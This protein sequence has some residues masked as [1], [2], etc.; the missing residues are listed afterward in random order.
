MHRSLP[1]PGTAS[2]R[3]Q[4][5]PNTLP[6]NGLGGRAES[7]AVR[8]E[9]FPRESLSTA[10]LHLLQCDV[11][12]QL[13][14]FFYPSSTVALDETSLFVCM[15]K[16]WLYGEPL[17]RAEI[18]KTHFDLVSNTLT[19]WIDE[20]EATATLRRPM[21]AGPG[22]RSELVGR[23]LA[24]NKVR[25]T[26]WK[27]KSL[28]DGLSTE[29]LLCMAFRAMTNTEGLETLFRDGLARLELGMSELLCSI[30]PKIVITTST[31]SNSIQ[32]EDDI[33]SDVATSRI[34]SGSQTTIHHPASPHQGVVGSTG[35]S[36]IKDGGPLEELEE[37]PTEDV[38][39]S[40]KSG[41][42]ILK[43]KPSSLALLGQHKH[44]TSEAPLERKRTLRS[45]SRRE[46]TESTG[47]DRF[48]LHNVLAHML[49]ESAMPL[50]DIQNV[51]QDCHNDAR[52]LAKGTGKN[53]RKR[54]VEDG[55]PLGGNRVLRQK[56]QV[57]PTP[58]KTIA[59]TAVQPVQP[60][61]SIGNEP[62]EVWLDDPHAASYLP[63]K[64]EHPKAAWRRIF[65]NRGEMADYRDSP[66]AWM[67]MMCWKEGREG[68]GAGWQARGTEHPYVKRVLG[69][70]QVGVES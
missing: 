28:V 68:G 10:D 49:D 26:R 3:L 4:S 54:A 50:A 24:M 62:L 12:A 27:E 69:G 6:D 67:S 40:P 63:G 51:P 59:A 20:C 19:A 5:Q 57:K 14:A 52:L 53:K 42:V 33:G 21:Q 55:E 31:S 45:R 70:L 41:L 56:T 11:T 23:V 30:Q 47:S 65:P 61:I 60:R 13:F 22:S 17:F 38:A 46:G 25:A 7:L 44:E 9:P 43:V 37:M 34:I 58:T 8:P 1:A 39:T 18:P 48:D 16:L 2:G 29:D 35:S 64:F 32:L 66:D 36:R 15:R